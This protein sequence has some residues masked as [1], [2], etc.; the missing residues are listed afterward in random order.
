M[1][2]PVRRRGSQEQGFS[3]IEALVTLLITAVISLMMV[4]EFL[5]TGKRGYDHQLGSRVN[6]QTR[7]LLDYIAYDVRMLGAGLP[8]GQTGFDIGD[9]T[10]GDAPLPVLLTSNAT[11]LIMRANEKGVHSVLTSNFTPSAGSSTFNVFDASDLGIGDTVYISD[12][13]TGGSSGL[14]GTVRSLSGNAVT[15]NLAMTYAAG[16]SFKPGA[17]VNRI[18]TITYANTADGITR[19]GLGGLNLL[20]SNS[21]FTIEY[22][23]AAGAAL[24]LPL[25][26]AAV[27]DQ[28]TSVRLNVTVTDEKVFSSGQPATATASQVISLR[29]LILMR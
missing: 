8:L 25:T 2:E 22:L 17:S 19:D 4:V 21:S 29:N 1:G 13:P 10:L 23:D 7:T 9:A 14:M 18:T 28:L 15:L 5:D 12:M 16:A 26:A 27:K 11:T 6:E 24:A 20:Q 3:L